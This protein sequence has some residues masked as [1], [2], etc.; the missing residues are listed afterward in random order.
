MKN[1]NWLD[2]IFCKEKKNNIVGNYGINSEKS[3]SMR[4]YHMHLHIIVRRRTIEYTFYM[5]SRNQIKL[6]CYLKK[7]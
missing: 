6:S 5:C 3:T 2:G 7:Y 4:L 1:I